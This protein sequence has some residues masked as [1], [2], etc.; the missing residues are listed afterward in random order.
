[1]HLGICLFLDIFILFYFLA[2]SSMIGI[3][4]LWEEGGTSWWE[5]GL[6]GKN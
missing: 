3:K 2:V 4:C 1:M 6:M 5:V